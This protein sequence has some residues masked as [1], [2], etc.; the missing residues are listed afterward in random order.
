MPKKRTIRSLQKLCLET[1]GVRMAQIWVRNCVGNNLDP[2]LVPCTWEPFSELAGSLVQELL[3]LMGR[4]RHLNR[5]VL[6]LLLVPQL[7]ELNLSICP[8][9]V[10]RS[11]AQTI[12]RRC[13]NLSSLNLH[14]C[15]KIPT[16][17]L[18]NLV[19]GLPRLTTLDLSRTQCDTLVLSAMATHC[20]RIRELD[21][22]GCKR[23]SPG[24]L[25]YLAYDPGAGSY[26]CQDLR[27]LSINGVVPTAQSQDLVG[28]LAFMLLALPSLR[29]ME[30]EA[31]GEA[32]WLIHYQQFDGAFVSPGFPSL[33]ALVRYRIA[34]N[35][36][37]E[38]FRLT[39]PLREIFIRREAFLPEVSAVCPHLV[40]I[41]VLVGNG[42]G[43]G[44]AFFSWSHLTCLTLRCRG[45]RDLRDLLPVMEGLR[46]QLRSFSFCGFTFQDELSFHNLL[47]L[48]LNLRKLSV[49]LLPPENDNSGQEPDLDAIAWDYNLAP[50]EFPHLREFFLMPSDLEDPLPAQ[51]AA[52]LKPSLISLLKHSPRLRNLE[53]FCLPFSLDEVFDKVLE[54]P[55]TALV[56][57]RE[58]ILLQNE[59]TVRTIHRLLSSDNQLSALSLD[60]C[61]DIYEADY[62]ELLERVHAEGLDVDI[63]WQ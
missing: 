22:S 41:T 40:A 54:P 23:L 59:V 21:L 49:S 1:V 14:G 61:P 42:V 46:A 30:H 36:N 37:E 50:L 13:T 24:S 44:Q 63:T 58:L 39:L 32:M 11:V 12:A 3:E 56:H 31:I 53:L 62:C 19:K 51:H 38:G 55:G 35:M 2:Y 28:S 16:E 10:G 47:S 6:H 60:G 9:L 33:E 25:L 45:S 34:T 27:K 43:L 17:S 52:V 18:A 8:Q 4:T 7:M 26:C 29:V 15:I 5:A 57:L 48:C 20:R